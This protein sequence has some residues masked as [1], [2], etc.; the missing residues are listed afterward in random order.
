MRKAD[1][2]G[3]IQTIIA[4]LLKYEE[5]SHRLFHPLDGE[6]TMHGYSTSARRY[7]NS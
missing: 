5:I 1:H 3:K 2:L 4:I 6:H 7:G